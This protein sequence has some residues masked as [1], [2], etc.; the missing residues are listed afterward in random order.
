M[1]NNPIVTFDEIVDA[2]KSI[3]ECSISNEYTDDLNYLN[4]KYESSIKNKVDT[5]KEKA[6]YE[7]LKTLEK[8][9]DT[10]SKVIRSNLVNEVSNLDE[11]VIKLESNYLIGQERRKL[12][13]QPFFVKKISD[14]SLKSSVLFNPIE[15]NIEEKKNLDDIDTNTVFSD[16][17]KEIIA[18]F[19]EYFQEEI[20]LANE[21]DNTSEKTI[22]NYVIP[23]DIKVRD[24]NKLN[25]LKAAIAKAKSIGN[26]EL[27]DKL[28]EKY[29]EE[30]NK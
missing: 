24:I 14:L 19:P 29:Y 6:L 5:D 27:I 9:I 18:N 3:L 8:N 2:L 20:K 16:F 4:V 26:Q 28:E 30:L 25:K 13:A 22:S 21:Y 15:D 10:Y 7:A 11:S 17:E 12:S 23:E 1:N